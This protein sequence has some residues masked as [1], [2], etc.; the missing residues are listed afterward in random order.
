[1]GNVFDEK[2]LTYYQINGGVDMWIGGDLNGGVNIDAIGFAPRNDDNSIVPTDIYELFYWDEQW[3]S[4]GVKKP[5]G[6]SAVYRNVPQKAL[7]WLRNLT[8]GREER[9][10]TYENGRQ[11]WW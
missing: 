2:I 6:D 7:L 10:F 1:M 9:P 4:L 5:D 3:N 8:K 11:I